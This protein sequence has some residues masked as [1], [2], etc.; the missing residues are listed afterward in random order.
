M[1]NVKE[2]NIGKKTDMTENEITG[3]TEGSPE[4]LGKANLLV[5]F[6]DLQIITTSHYQPIWHGHFAV[7]LFF[8]RMT[9]N[10]VVKNWLNLASHD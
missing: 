5:V 8:S 10:V 1:T 3:Y 2:H 4:A 9:H 6:L 7:N